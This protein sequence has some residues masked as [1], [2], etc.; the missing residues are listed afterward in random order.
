MTAATQADE[1]AI[2]ALIATWMSAS[3]AGDIATVLELMTEDVVFL[4][5]G[6]PPMIGKAA[7]AAAA[8]SQSRPGAPTFDGKSEIQE[9]RVAGDW[10]SIW[11]KLAVT[12]TPPGGKAVTRSGYT[13]SILRKEHGR[14]RLARDANMLSAPDPQAG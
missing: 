5:A 4:G 6:R 1:E 14:W 3:K 10:A 9:I 11:T 8:R 12:V 2:R 13:L 7:F